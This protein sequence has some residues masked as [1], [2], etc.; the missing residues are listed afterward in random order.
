MLRGVFNEDSVSMVGDLAAFV[1]L[2]I[3][4]ATGSAAPQAIAAIVI[5]LLLIRISLCLVHRN[6]AFLL[7]QPVTSSE[8]DQ[9]RTFLVSDPQVTQ[10]HELLVFFLG[11]GQVWGLARV[12]VKR[13]LRAL[14]ISVLVDKT[15]SRAEA[16]LKE[17]RSRRH[18]DRRQ[19]GA[20]LW[21]GS[22]GALRATGS[23]SYAFGVLAHLSLISRI[24]VI[25]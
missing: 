1:G 23:T 5:G 6:H 17:R 24:V 14:E 13:S 8:H 16:G 20:D 15:G 21:D 10:V 12:S 19:L 11:S 22:D 25:V 18:R 2:G 9:V 3:S 7:G 4:Q